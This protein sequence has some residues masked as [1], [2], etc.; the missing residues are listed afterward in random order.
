MSERPSAEQMERIR[1]LNA[2][3]LKIG[4]ECTVDQHV[5]MLLTE[6]DAVTRERDANDQVINKLSHRVA[7]LERERHAHLF[8]HRVVAG[9]L[10]HGPEIFAER[11]QRFAVF[12]AAEQDE[13]G[14]PIEARQLPENVADVGADAEV[15][16]LPRVDTYPHREII[17]IAVK[18]TTTEGTVSN[19]GH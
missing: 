7:D 11:R 14:L 4:A 15:V 10:G 17:S 5:T 19:G 18:S 2:H 12:R 3:I 1:I 9:P 13:L 8:G 6:L 16:Q